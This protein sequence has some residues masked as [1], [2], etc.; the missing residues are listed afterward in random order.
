MDCFTLISYFAVVS[1]SLFVLISTI[2]LYKMHYGKK[3]KNKKQKQNK[4]K[5]HQKKQL[6]ERYQKCKKCIVI[7]N[8]VSNQYYCK[9]RKCYS[10][11]LS[12]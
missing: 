6:E 9:Y 11:L 2:S 1:G 4:T 12:V 7:D 5:K 8:V 3:K 10:A